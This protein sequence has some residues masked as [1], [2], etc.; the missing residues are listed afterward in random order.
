[1]KQKLKPYS[2]IPSAAC[3]KKV[4][5]IM[6]QDFWIKIKVRAS[7]RGIGVSEFIRIVLEEHCG[8]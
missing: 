8:R 1:M 3:D 5:V 4:S 2:E 6:P 7:K